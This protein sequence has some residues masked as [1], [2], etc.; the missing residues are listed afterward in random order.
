MQP[1]YEGLISSSCG[2]LQP[3]ATPEGPFWPVGD[4]AGRPDRHTDGLTDG[5]PN[6]KY[7]LK[8]TTMGY[9]L[10]WLQS[11]KS[12]SNWCLNIGC[13]ALLQEPPNLIGSLCHL[14]EFIVLWDPDKYQCILQGVFW[15]YEA[16]GRTDRRTSLGERTGLYWLWLLQS[17]TDW[18]RYKR[19]A[20]EGPVKR[21]WQKAT[22][23]QFV[24]VDA[25]ISSVCQKSIK[26]GSNTLRTVK[27]SLDPDKLG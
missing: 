12:R 8:V 9:I 17:V 1:P 3:S 2:G 7:R 11:L 10:L 6:L 19:T 15:Q 14:L 13:S 23:K 18:L 4:F 20:L 21:K 27:I 16:N 22:N 5:R 24:Q 26:T 25:T